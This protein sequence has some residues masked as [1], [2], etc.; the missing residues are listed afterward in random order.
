MWSSMKSSPSEANSKR[1][2]RARLKEIYRK[3]GWK[4]L[5]G[6]VLLYLVR[7]VV[8]YLLLPYLIAR[9]IFG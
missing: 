7:D 2:K 4:M 1:S 8:L 5:V 3:Y 6:A 9:G